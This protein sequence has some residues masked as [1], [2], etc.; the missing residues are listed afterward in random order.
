MHRVGRAGRQAGFLSA[1]WKGQELALSCIEKASG[2]TSTICS[3]QLK[4]TQ[5]PRLGKS[6]NGVG[7]R[8]IWLRSDLMNSTFATNPRTI[9]P[10][11]SSIPAEMGNSAT[12]AAC[13]CKPNATSQDKVSQQG[14]VYRNSIGGGSNNF[15]VLCKKE[16][17]A[18][19]SPSCQ[20]R[21]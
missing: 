12:G 2:L 4:Q 14:V 20:K 19:P 17:S 16:S 7:S 15:S 13:S 1:P 5:V 18:L 3:L 8:K 6:L 9:L 21:Q 10:P 11:T